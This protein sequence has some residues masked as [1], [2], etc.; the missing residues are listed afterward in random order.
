MGVG[1]R[2][3][4]L[5]NPF[6]P[7]DLC[8]LDPE[9][10]TEDTRWH[11]LE[12]MIEPQRLGWEPTLYH[13]RPHER[14]TPRKLMKAGAV[15]AALTRGGPLPLPS[16][17]LDTTVVYGALNGATRPTE[18]TMSDTTIDLSD[19]E[20]RTLRDEARELVRQF[21]MTIPAGAE[22][23]GYELNEFLFD[24]LTEE[25]P[26]MAAATHNFTKSIV[27][28]PWIREGLIEDTGD[29]TTMSARNR[30]MAKYRRVSIEVESPVAPEPLVMEALYALAERHREEYDALVAQFSP[31]P[32]P[33]LFWA[34]LRLQTKIR[35]ARKASEELM[36]LRSEL[37]LP[38]E[39]EV[40]EEG[41]VIAFERPDYVVVSTEEALE[42]LTDTRGVGE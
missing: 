25:R 11:Q 34:E 16:V 31:H 2:G 24:R 14:V 33:E 12:T 32:H 26:E 27:I 22:F 41:E 20:M 9:E 40:A 19:D 6:C 39:G 30:P 17:D 23:T 15:V 35:E 8:V 28:D 3:C 29:R 42:Y 38:M 5:L 37:G 10:H 13:P 1:W 21:L 18:Q 7:D 36:R 4:L